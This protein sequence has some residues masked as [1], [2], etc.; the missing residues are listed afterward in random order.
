[1]VRQQSPHC[2]ALR[3]EALAPEANDALRAA[4]S[5]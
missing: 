4:A 3:F 5:V 2:Y 1:V